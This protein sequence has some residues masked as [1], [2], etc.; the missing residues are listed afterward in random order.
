MGEDMSLQFR[1]VGIL[2]LVALAAA[3][4]GCTTAVSPV[5]PDSA[6]ADG[7]QQGSS[8][9]AASDA[10]AFD[11][12]SDAGS[13]EDAGA[14]DADAPAT[15]EVCD[16]VDNDGNGIID[17]VDLTG[18][19]ICDC[20]NIATLGYEGQWGQG[21]IFKNWLAGRTSNG[22]AVSLGSKTLTAETLAP[23]Q[24]LVVQDVRPGTPGT[25]GKGQGIG[26]V[27]SDAEVEALESWVSQGGGVMTLLGYSDA[28]EVENVNKLLAPF[29][30]SYGSNSV[31]G[32]GDGTSKAITHW[33]THPIA[34]GVQKV[35]SDWGYPVSGGTLIAWEPVEGEW[36]IGRVVEH[37]SGHVFAWGDEWITYNTEWQD[38][39]DY[40]VERF[41]INSIKWLTVAGNC[42]VPTGPN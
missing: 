24:V 31:L 4:A 26:R 27:Y 36:D 14:S 42:Q 10:G 9:A 20:L 11:A 1:R 30:L 32:V 16:G 29:G 22:G 33:A 18:D 38:R 34:E 2:S 28:S 41:W 5:S 12:A 35:G 37:G 3:S 23:F 17:D 13:S 21:D 7:S 25:E 15:V 19:G 6:N 40:Q 39:P 8:D